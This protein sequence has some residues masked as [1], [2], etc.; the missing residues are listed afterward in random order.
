MPGP[1]YRLLD[2]LLTCLVAFAALALGGRTASA[3]DA[4]KPDPDR[5]LS[6]YFLVEDGD[7]AV[8]GMPLL[9]TK[10]DVAISG[11]VADVTV[12]QSYQNRGKRPIHAKYVFPASTRAAVHG[13]KMT[14]GDRVVTAKIKER[15]QAKREYEHAKESGKS[16]SL[17]EEDRPNVF[18]MSVANILPGDHIDVT[19]NYAELLVPTAGVYELVYPTV[20]GPRYSNQLAAKAKA[21]DAFVA[22]PYL[23]AGADAPSTFAL[24]GTLSS[25]IPVQTVESPTHSV[26]ETRD[27]PGLV[28]FS[29][30]PAEKNGGN[31][32]FVLRY[33]LAGQSI[34]SGLSL[35][36]GG[37]EKQFLLMVEPPR[38]VT[39]ADLPPR[40]YVFILDVSGSMEGFPLDT[41]K[42]VLR[43]LSKSLRPQDA[44]NVLLFSGTSYLLSPR[45][46]PATPENVQRALTAIDKERGGGGTELLPALERALTLSSVK[47]LSRS[48]VVLTDGYIDADKGAI[49]LVRSRLGDANVFAFGIGSSVNRFLIEGIARAGQGEPF[50][51]MDPAQA[52]DAG[53]KFRDYI[54]APVLTGI[55]V[56]Y[57]GFDAYDVEPKSIPD[58]FAARPVVVQGKYRGALHGTI[59][60]EGASGSGAYVQR[61]DAANASPHV[62]NRALPFLWARSRIATLSDFGFGEPSPAAQKD[63]TALGLQYSLLTAYTSFIAVS[64]LVRTKPG[65]GTD[66]NQPLPLPAGVSELAVSEPVQSAPEPEFY[67]LLGLV[68]CAAI[69]TYVIR[70]AR[71]SAFAR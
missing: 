36:D 14:I 31:R 4:P 20:V 52:A 2:L 15:E 50:V 11:V 1:R 42:T 44:F 18:T 32:D 56:R 67:L 30:D 53:N 34:Q 35:Y 61:F 60:V 43:E 9:G 8:D 65:S 5:T 7:P 13:M 3:V 38:R 10:V 24:S 26:K 29:L 41:A 55:K 57:D 46:L 37:S 21:R 17:L 40:E 6:P 48:F 22:T 27:N 59:T 51:V 25:G 70:T 39:P 19:L 33:G 58:V 28:R 69:T 62:E 66:V 16:A 23:H 68:L 71:R 49:D 47:G 63:I 45:S 64:E 54:A 12:T